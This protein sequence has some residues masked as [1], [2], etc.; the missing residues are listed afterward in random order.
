MSLT[1]EHRL[2]AELEASLLTDVGDGFWECEFRA[3]GSACE[4]FYAAKDQAAAEHFRRVAFDWLA[5]FEVRCSRFLADSEVSS[6]NA[7][8]GRDWVPIH[9]QTEML[10]D[11]CDH[12]H[13]VT[14]GAFDAT[15]L[16]LSRLW[17]WKQQ[18]DSLPSLEEIA[19]AKKVIGWKRIQRAPGRILLPEPGMMLD[20]GGVGKEFAVDCLKALALSCGI[21]HV[22]VDL[23]GDIAVQGEPPEGGGWYIGLEDPANT[24][25]AHCGIRLRSGGAVA[26]SGDYRRCFQFEGRTYGHILDCRTGWPVANGTR[27]ATVI[28]PRCTTAGVLSTSAMIVGGQDAITMLERSPGV[29]GCLWRNNLLH[30]TRGFRRNV[31]PQGWDQD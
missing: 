2:R 8:A 26:T 29:Q 3:L 23:G 1:T 20:F 18:H 17:D 16:P 5:E 22:M 31:L 25:Q 12:Y 30:E 15:S 13:F 6:I 10:L 11:L 28:A 27:S 7:Q 21:E 9:A 4:L 19:A 14:E 24:E